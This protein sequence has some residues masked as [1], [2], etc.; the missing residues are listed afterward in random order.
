MEL[1]ASLMRKFVEEIKRNLSE[2]HSCDQMGN[3]HFFFF[4]FF[5]E[6]K[7][8]KG[9]RL[10]E[11]RLIFQNQCAKSLIPGVTQVAVFSIGPKTKVAKSKNN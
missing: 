11:S 7:P 10:W 4:F 9:C 6:I 5:L 8:L 3:G 1:K 2:S